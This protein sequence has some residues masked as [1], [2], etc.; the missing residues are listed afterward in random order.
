MRKICII[1][2]KGGVAKTTT[3][4]NLASALAGAE[5]RVLVIDLDPQGNISTCLCIHNDK[6]MYDLLVDDADIFDCIVNVSE[7]LDVIT[8]DSS[9]AKAELIITGQTSRETV[10]RRKLEGIFNYDYVL[11]DCPPSLS[12]LNI[13]A[14]LFANEAFVPVATDFLALDALK[15][16][17][18]TIS[19]I[20]EL[21]DHD[22]KI[23][24]VIPTLYDQRNKSCKE[25]LKSIKRGYEE[26][27]SSP[28][29]INSKLR[30]APSV[31][32]NI[33]EYAKRSPGANDYRKLAKTVMEAEDYL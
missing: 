1:N 26:L 16:I 20:N 28:I 2:Q 32:K 19:E 5:K 17:T 23:T 4:V 29:R 6:T 10:L 31:G 18:Q 22:I 7:G 11:I 8:S 21:F 15:K 14:L 30:E 3:T 27:V 25:T 12:L 9:L 33:F 24:Q 13:N